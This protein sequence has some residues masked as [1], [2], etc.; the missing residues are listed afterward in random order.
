MDWPCVFGW[1]AGLP[2]GHLPCSGKVSGAPVR[3]APGCRRHGPARNQQTNNQ[4]YMFNS[5]LYRNWSLKK[6]H[7]AIGYPISTDQSVPCWH[8][9]M[10]VKIWPTTPIFPDMWTINSSLHYWISKFNKVIDYWLSGQSV[11]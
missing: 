11:C 5:I 6:E 9:V 8:S 2:S 3:S 10:A 1:R 4:N 7:Y